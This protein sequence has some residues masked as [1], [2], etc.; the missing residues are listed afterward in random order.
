MIRIACLIRPWAPLVY[1][2]NRIHEKCGV[3]LAIV[4]AP[5]QD[6]RWSRAFRTLKSEGW[7]LPTR[8]FSGQGP[9][10]ARQQTIADFNRILGSGWQSLNEG[11]PSIVVQDINSDL[12]YE[13]LQ[14]DGFDL[15]IDHGTSLLHPRII[16]QARLALNL[17]WGLSPYY[18]GTHC[19][20]WALLN[21]DPYN[22]GVTIHKLT[23]S[24][25]GGEILGQVRAEVEP[26]DTANAINM[27]LTR[28][29]TDLLDRA[30]DLMLKGAE[31]PFSVQ[32][33]SV[34]LLASNLQWSDLLERQIRRMEHRGLVAEMLRKP[35]R[36]RRLPIVELAVR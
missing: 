19:T 11:I 8:I 31:L 24:I 36:R 28:L 29:G 25:D 21:W 3:A 14:R 6:A 13:R 32:D 30:I 7:A 22:I 2:T 26:I 5:R 16:E 33:S 4:E 18:R 10:A 34:G 1:M 9:F 17:H 27:K 20:E 12:A 35:A 23:P 15:V